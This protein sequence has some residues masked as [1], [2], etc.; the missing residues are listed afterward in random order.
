MLKETDLSQFM[1]PQFPIWRL[2]L[3][4]YIS[5]FQ[6]G[7][8]EQKIKKWPPW[9]ARVLSMGYVLSVKSNEYVCLKQR[10]RNT[11]K[12]VTLCPPFCVARILTWH[13]QNNNVHSTKFQLQQQIFKSFSFIHENSNRVKKTAKLHND[14]QTSRTHC[15]TYLYIWNQSDY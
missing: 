15:F 8:L 11:E 9:S 2:L 1:Q 7:G 4:I 6:C 3:M 13:V 14:I 10:V 5:I 12:L